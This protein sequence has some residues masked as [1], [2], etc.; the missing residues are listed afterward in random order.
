[1]AIEVISTIKPKNNGSFPIVEAKDVSVDENGTRL[2]EKLSNLGTPSVS[3]DFSVPTFDLTALGLVAVSLDGTQTILQTDTTEIVSALEKGTIRFSL[4]VALGEA[5]APFSV[6]PNIACSSADGVYMCTA[7][8]ELNGKILVTFI[9]QEGFVVV[10]ASAFG[11]TSDNEIPS[12]D[13]AALGLDAVTLDGNETILQTDTTEIVSALEKGTIRFS[14]DVAVGEA[15]APFSVM[16]NIACSPAEGAYMC[17][18][19]YDFNG[20]ILVTFIVQEG[21]VVVMASALGEAE[22]ESVA[23]NIDLSKFNTS[24]QIT[25][26]YADGS[27]KTT[28]IEFDADGNPV[29]ITDGDGNVTT[30]TW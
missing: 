26:T 5:V 20:K 12:F 6:I 16:P 22:T 28:T 25:E 30:L 19:V 29:K 14:L 13:L 18:A 1:M 3:T 15:V 24:G 10:Q 17:T 21:F 2:S 9:V 27:T 23:T 11:E 4:D 8:Y 7:V